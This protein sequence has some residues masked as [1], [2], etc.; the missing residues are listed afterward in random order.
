MYDPQYAAEES[1]AQQAAEESGGQ[2][3]AEE[4]TAA[5]TSLSS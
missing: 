5:P 2:H 1:G 3:A 4:E